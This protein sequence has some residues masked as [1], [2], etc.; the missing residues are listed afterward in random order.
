MSSLF[1]IILL[2][3]LLL[4]RGDCALDGAREALA[5]TEEEIPT[6]GAEMSAMKE[7]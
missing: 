4:L 2:L 7:K 1:I 5:D 6:V 3:L